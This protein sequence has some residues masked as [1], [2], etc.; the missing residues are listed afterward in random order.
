MKIFNQYI[1]ILKNW[2]KKLSYVNINKWIYQDKKF[3]Q[4]QDNIKIIIHSI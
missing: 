3:M 4:T 2:N 1:V